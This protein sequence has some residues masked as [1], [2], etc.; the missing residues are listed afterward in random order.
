MFTYC[1]NPVWEVVTALSPIVNVKGAS[2]NTQLQSFYAICVSSGL[3]NKYPQIRQGIEMMVSGEAGDSILVSNLQ[4]NQDL[5]IVSLE[6]TPWVNNA[7]AETLR[8]SRLS[9]ILNEA[10]VDDTLN[11]IW[12]KLQQLRNQ[13]GGW[14]WCPGMKSNRWTTQDLLLYVG[15][16][17]QKGYLPD[18][19]NFNAVISSAFS[20]CDKEI[21]NEYRKLDKSGKEY[22]V[23]SLYSYLY[24]KSL[25]PDIRD[26]S[27]FI[28]IRNEAMR[29][30]EK[31]WKTLDIESKAKAALIFYRAGNKKLSEEIL[32]S[33][34]EYA[35]TT[36][37]GIFYANLDS[38]NQRGG[39]L[40]ATAQVLTAFGTISPSDH[41]IEGLCQWL[42]LQKQARAW[43]DGTS[44]VSAIDALLSFAEEWIQ[45]S[46][47]P[48]ISIAGRAMDIDAF[49][50][51][52]GSCCTDISVGILSEKEIVIHRE[53]ASPAWG[54]VL[55]QSIHP[56]EDIKAYA[57]D[58]LNISKSYLCLS[59]ENGRETAIASTDFQIGNKVR[60]TLT[61]ES[62]RDMEFVVIA[63]ER[64]ACLQP[65][66]QLSGY[67]CV[68]NLW[69]YKEVRNSS[70]NLYIPFLPRG[71]HLI[72]YDAYISGEGDFANGIAA[73]QCL[74]APEL[75]AHSGG[76]ELKVE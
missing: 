32:Q 55:V 70:T 13:D 12:I 6:N 58:E 75:T 26:A 31:N 36:N 4:K 7:Q 66:E 51:L 18:L 35:T 68:D 30:M 20:Y 14:S 33:L 42:L 25:F 8:M 5:K 16:L 71:R 43:Q 73:I 76:A 48:E 9:T 29:S 44:S 72:T 41:M 19:P 53:S 28:S 3:A 1:D 50:K 74:Y 61:R 39:N 21:I 37:N 23:A 62:D 59:N 38:R 69:L 17:K 49:E 11:K 40:A 57:I 47:A 63:D 10:D 45:I 46:R 60:V 34:K 27:G 15:M 22:F 65:T 67:V 2:L 56:M 64:S 52:T 54:A 24:V